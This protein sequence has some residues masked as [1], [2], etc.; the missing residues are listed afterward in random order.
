[1]HV[2]CLSPS[3]NLPPNPIHSPTHCLTPYYCIHCTSGKTGIILMPHLWE[4]T[5]KY[6]RRQ[7][8]EKKQLLP[9]T[10]PFCILQKN[11]MF[12]WLPNHSTPA[13]HPAYYLSGSRDL[14]LPTLYHHEKDL[15]ALPRLSSS[16]Q[17]PSPPQQLPSSPPLPPPTPPPHL[18][19]LPPVSPF[20]PTQEWDLCLFSLSSLISRDGWTDRFGMDGGT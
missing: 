9:L 12:V 11:N 10:L 14:S 7:T 4:D 2:P 13:T 19:H 6:D 5:C 18:Q 1:M 8:V 3:P 16:P 20:S 15:P 17:Q